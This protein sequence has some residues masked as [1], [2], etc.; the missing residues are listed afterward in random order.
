MLETISG[1]QK[2]VHSYLPTAFENL[3][4]RDVKKVVNLQ[5]FINQVLDTVIFSPGS[6]HRW[7][8]RQCKTTEAYDQESQGQ[9]RVPV[10]LEGGDK[11]RSWPSLSSVTRERSTSNRHLRRK[12]IPDFYSIHYLQS[13]YRY[14]QC[15]PRP[16]DT[17]SVHTI[18]KPYGNNSAPWYE[19]KCPRRESSQTGEQ[20]ICR[21]R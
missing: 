7:R 20:A 8:T 13:W 2:G 9:G 21:C 6:L 1:S 11:N 10:I 19:L 17:I 18:S 14:K 16:C 3:V 4:L 12:E 5:R 15:D